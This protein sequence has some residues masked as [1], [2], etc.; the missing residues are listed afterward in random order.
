MR[1]Q[2]VTNHP[3]VII[4]E[5]G[6]SEKY[7]YTYL[8]KDFERVFE[9][10]VSC[11]N[12]VLE[13]I[14]HSLDFLKKP[15][16]VVVLVKAEYLEYVGRIVTVD[17]VMQNVVFDFEQKFEAYREQGFNVVFMPLSEIANISKT[18]K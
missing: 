3:V 18:I 5:F 8:T 13:C 10:D 16:D 9:L 4:A 2:D 1:I 17:P 15:S 12:Y 7:K 14:C 11:D 6:Y